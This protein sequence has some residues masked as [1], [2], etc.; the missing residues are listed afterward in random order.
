MEWGK[1][2][3]VRLHGE[4]IVEV[5]WTAL[6]CGSLGDLENLVRPCGKSN[7]TGMIVNKE[8][9]LNVFIV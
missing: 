2:W 1:E 9:K 3:S 7:T 4:N 8:D 6:T 5:A